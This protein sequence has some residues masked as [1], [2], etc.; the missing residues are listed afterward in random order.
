M[1]ADESNNDGGRRPDVQPVESADGERAERRAIAKEM[2]DEWTDDRYA[3]CYVD[4]DLRG[5][6]RIEIPWQQIASQ[7]H[8]QHD[9]KER[10]ADD[11]LQFARLLIRAKEQDLQQVHRHEDDHGRCAPRM[12]ADQERAPQHVL[13]NEER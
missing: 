6:V 8:R 2:V 12:E 4:R 9:E 3:R 10:D 13:I 11:P 1:K 5:E 7:A